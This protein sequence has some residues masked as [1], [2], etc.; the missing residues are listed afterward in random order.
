M[1]LKGSAASIDYR[2][3]NTSLQN[4]IHVSMVHC[5]SALKP[6]ASRLPCY[7]TPPMCV[8]DVIGA[9]AWQHNNQ[10]KIA[11]IATANTAQ[12]STLFLP[13]Y[14]QLTWPVHAFLYP[15]TRA[16]LAQQNY[17]HQIMQPPS[18]GEHRNYLDV[19]PGLEPL[20]TA[21]LWW[22]GM[23]PLAIHYADDTV[24]LFP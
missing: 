22:N 19:A 16:T 2:H 10:K 12:A 18:T 14:A 1:F 7:C 11:N 23:R 6:G 15:E 5:G 13:A 4:N 3:T 21:Q 9:L 20:A 8:P 24:L 17:A